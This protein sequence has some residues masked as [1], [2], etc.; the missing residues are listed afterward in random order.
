MPI[1]SQDNSQE[2]QLVSIVIPTFNHAHYLGRALASVSDQ[3][4]EKW[5]AIVVDNHSTDNTEE[6]V[7]SFSDPRIV[8]LKTHNNGV[9]A[10][11]RNMGIRAA[12]GA[13]IAFLD[14]DDWW[15]PNKLKVCMEYARPSTDLIYHDLAISY[16]RSS[17]FDKQTISSWQVRRPIV[18]D[19]LLRGNAIATS[20]VVVKKQLLEQINGMN[21]DPNMI[22]AE[23]YNTWLRIAEITDG[24][25]YIPR[26][27]GF[28]RQHG[29]GMSQKDMSEPAEFACRAFT[30]LLNKKQRLKFESN[31]RYAGGR[32]SFQKGNYLEA[33]KDL[34]FCLRYGNFAISLK[35][36]F[37]LLLGGILIYQRGR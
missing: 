17:L 26:N 24:F 2:T 22:A 36:L 28:Y 23:D 6:I 37:M 14:S 16:D 32:F 13:W 20:S 29:N 8:L 5:E 34:L 33:R 25:K 9:I 3:T 11:S 12:K 27:L 4:Y 35:S 1:N 31:I 18:K 15:T 10:V 30:H 19:L 21:V 7:A